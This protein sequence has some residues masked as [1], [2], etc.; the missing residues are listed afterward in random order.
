MELE[1]RGN[2]DNK[3]SLS[4]PRFKQ[5]QHVLVTS[6]DL[7]LIGGRIA[8]HSTAMATQDQNCCHADWCE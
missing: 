4:T 2:C 5:A 8:R 7:T 3:G 6:Q 1:G